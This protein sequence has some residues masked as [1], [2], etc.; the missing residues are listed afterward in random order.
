M[1]TL[2]LK[3]GS[4]KEF[5]YRT[6]EEYLGPVLLAEGLI[7]GESGEYGLMISAVD[8]ETA[9]WEENQRGLIWSAMRQK[10]AWACIRMWISSESRI[11]LGDLCL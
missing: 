6:D 10:P 4:K 1:I 9:S 5:D 8:G 7:R 2:T 11:L 3:D